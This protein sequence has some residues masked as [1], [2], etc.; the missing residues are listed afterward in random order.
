MTRDELR[1]ELAEMKL[2]LIK[3]MVATGFGIAVVTARF[4]LEDL[5]VLALTYLPPHGVPAPQRG[6]P[7][8]TAP[9]AGTETPGRACDAGGSSNSQRYSLSGLAS[10]RSFSPSA[11]TT[12]STVSKFGMRSPD[13]A[14]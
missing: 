7:L 6:G 10:A 9:P 8:A 12:F 3:W 4:D 5:L 14:L 1:P 11:L 2:D 13:S